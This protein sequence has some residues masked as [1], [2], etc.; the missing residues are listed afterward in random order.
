MKN[1][2]STLLWLVVL[3]AMFLGAMVVNNRYL[4]TLSLDLTEDK[5][6]SLTQGSKEIA[7][8]VNDVISLSLFFSESNSSGMTN[9]RDYKQRVE[10]LLREYVK[11]GKG[12]IRLTLVNPQPFSEAEDRAAELGLTDASVSMGQN[13]LYF[14]L[15]GTNSSGDTMIISFFD[16]SKE[17]FLEYDVSSLLHKLNAPDPIHLTIVTDLEVA[18]G[19]NPLTREVTPAYVLYQQLKDIF[20]VT[21]IS[22][23]DEN[24][25][26]DTE[27][28]LMWHPQNINQALLKGTDQF[29]M[30]GGKGLFLL[31]AH[32]ESDPMA[33]MGSIGANSSMMP[34]MATYGISVD[35]DNV[36]LDAGTGLEVG[37][38]EGGVARHLG[39]LGLTKEQINNDDIT[40][41]DLDSINGASFGSLALAS[42]SQLRETVLLS[43]SEASDKMPTRAYMA[44]RNPRIFAENFKN[45]HT[46]FTLAARYTGRA[47]SHFKGA[48]LIKKTD[49]LNVVV[50]ADADIAAD[51]F[52]VQQSSFFGQSIFNQFADNGDFILNTLENLSGNEKLIGIR[53][54]GTFARPF[55]KVQSIQV[56]AEEKFR[57]QEKRLQAQ[58]EQ[59]E[60]Q[61]SDLKG[62]GD[63]LALSA[64]QQ[65][66]ITEFT[67]QRIAIRKSLR[68][69]QFQ[70]QKDIDELGNILKL[71]NIV[72]MPLILVVVLLLL[73]KLMRKRAP[74]TLLYANIDESIK[75]KPVGEQKMNKRRNSNKEDVEHVI[76]IDKADDA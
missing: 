56:A 7:Q 21:L 76:H 41:S 30:R 52:W 63:N 37:T 72:A 59:T 55:T 64:E 71:I 31:D 25:P 1:T 58:L 29:L 32:Y 35:S 10:S 27:V 66:T 40:S 53:S 39:F 22:N 33:E 49:N 61:L 15:A 45:G 17:A 38:V 57:E 3:G 67:K 42:N 26:S 70:L 18:G 50:I 62:Q 20:D 9:I 73:A 54:R 5:I 16:P 23:S 43:S 11:L 8:N 46:P 24:F 12:R 68:D 75:Q 34:L 74:K 51:R 14:G 47:P 60:V 19:P 2:F 28:L 69:V 36:V 6:Y 65:A 13:A 48:G 4:N 44:T